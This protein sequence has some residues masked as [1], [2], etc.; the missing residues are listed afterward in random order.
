MNYYTD[1]RK[2]VLIGAGMVGMSFAYV[3]MYSHVCDEL[4]IIDVDE[5]KAR[6]EAMD[7]NH[8]LAFSGGNMKIY[9]S[10]YNSVAD[11]D[12][13]VITAGVSQKPGESRISLLRRNSAILSSIAEKCVKNGFDGIFVIATNPV[14]LMTDM[15]Q[16]KTGFPKG[17][18][19]GSGTTLDTARLRYL[20]G[21]Y[22][23]VDPR[24]VHAYVMGE[25]GDSEF[26]PM[27][28]AYIS[29]KSLLS[30]CAQTDNNFDE[31]E[32]YEIEDEVRGAAQAIIEAKGA[33]YYG[34]GLAVL[35]IV[36]AIFGN[37][38]SILTVSAM[39][40][41]EYGEH[42]VYIGVP[43]LITREGVKRVIE[44]D[45]AEKE[46]EKL[47]ASCDFLRSVKKE[48]LRAGTEVF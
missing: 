20:V 33:T 48:V 18:V 40:D 36:R 11:A 19:L 35:R 42:D 12:I 34:I 31:S 24:N 39:L 6:G 16:R 43:A 5:K 17:R 47:S 3:L 41:G 13:V 30:I 25:H 32:L 8:G 1:R 45:L 22:F 44:L 29:T 10:D 46:R 38:K 4:A 2:V 26:V 9:A 37:E 21:S 7:L 28:Q 23:G 14:D 15:V 27:S